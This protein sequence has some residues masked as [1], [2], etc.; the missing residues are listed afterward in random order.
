MEHGKTEVFHFS[1]AWGIF[2]PSPLDFTSI[3]GSILTPKNIW[4]Y[5]EFFFNQKL[6]FQHHINFYT[7]KAISTIKCMK[8]LSN[9]T[10]SLNPLQKRQLYRYCTLSITLY[11][12]QLWYY[13]KAPLDYPLKTLRKMQ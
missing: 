5:F 13:N 3:G 10:R 2:N 12:F 1:R 8:I 11:G 7:N 4:Y 9:L 6:L